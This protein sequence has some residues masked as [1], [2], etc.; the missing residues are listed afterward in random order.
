MSDTG[1]I[2]D[3]AA[4]NR[5]GVMADEKDLLLEDEMAEL[6]GL[7]IQHLGYPVGMGLAPKPEMAKR[8]A[9]EL[10]RTVRAAD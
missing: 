7:A 9:A 3:A 4:C 5:E 8:L 1:S 6:I 10:L 2:T